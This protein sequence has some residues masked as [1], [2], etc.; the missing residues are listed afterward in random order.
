MRTIPGYEG[1]NAAWLGPANE[2][3]QVGTGNNSLL[4]DMTLTIPRD[5][6]ADRLTLMRSLDRLERRHD[7]SS[8]WRGIDGFQDQALRVI[9]GHARQAFDLTRE[10]PRLRERYGPG[11][12]QELLL[13][14]RLCEAGVISVIAM[15]EARDVRLLLQ[16]LHR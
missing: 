15:I 8:P 1:D 6:L 7:Q 16:L 12:G 4:A 9:T 2:P 5:R 10:D 3:F 11:L 13:A 14:R